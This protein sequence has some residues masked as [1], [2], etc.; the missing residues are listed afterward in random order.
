MSKHPS[1]RGFL[2]S[3][4]SATGATAVMTTFPPVIQRALAVSANNRTGTIRDVEH[5]VILMQENRSFDHYFGT[6]NGVR[7]FGD[8]FPIPVPSTTYINGRTV[9]V[10]PN[11]SYQAQPGRP[12]S[13]STGPAAI[14]PF[15]LNTTQTFA[16]MRVAGTPHSWTDAQAAWDHGR[17]HQWTVAKNNH[18]LGYFTQADMP[19][20]FALAN[21]F[22][23][24]DAYHAGSQTGTNTNRTFHWTGG[25]DPRGLGGGPVTDNSHDWFNTDPK[26]DYTWT[27]YPERL[28]AAGVSWQ[29]YQ[30]MDDNFTDNPLAGFKS[31]RDAWYGRAGYSTALRERGV[32][33]RDLDKL[34][35]D[36]LENKLPQ[37]SWI[38]ATAEGSEHPG[39]SSPA[40]GADYTSR[41]LE[42]LV[43]N[44]DVWSKTVL[45]V[46]FDENDGFFDH[47]PPPAAPSYVSSQA[48]PAASDLAGAST[49]DTSGEYNFVLNGS[50]ATYL[51]RPYGMG[52]RVPM[53]VVSPWSKGG[54]VN[55]QVFDH[56]SVLRFIEARF[57]VAETNI[58][59]W[60]RAVAGD[61]SSAFNFVDPND[62]SFFGQ[63][64]ATLALANQARA[65]SGTTMPPTPST[66]AL[67][68]QA[69]GV[70]PSRALPYELHASCRIQP[71][72]AATPV[73]LVFS[74]TGTQ[75]AVFH[76]YNR[77]DLAA[78]P[79]RYTV[80][81]GK[82]LSGQWAPTSAGQYD[83]WVLGPAGFHRHFTGNARRVAAA[84]QP[85]PEVSV[86]YDRLTG[87]LVVKL[88]NGGSGPCSFSL[89]ANAYFNAAAASYKVL[90]RSEQA[91][92]FPLASSGRWYDFSV[93]VAGQTDFSRRFAGRMENGQHGISDPAMGGTAIA[94]QLV[95]G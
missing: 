17:M 19:F 31:F 80:G 83:L 60:R 35:T 67:P 16:H 41:V 26:T 73:E 87:D 37:V 44:P 21:A 90:A 52:P 27:T 93:S 78:I 74:N 23:L 6:L 55:S 43:A 39:P 91:V 56:T 24:C 51:N 66:L 76:V 42:A 82:Q 3:V 64:P 75:A 77:K 72:L 40:Q 63:L 28:Q 1:R 59:P 71:T 53:Y 29:V 68:T 48:N 69:T 49:V 5:I 95:I 38:I 12:P 54:W 84:A 30:N 45:I 86:S 36:V 88:L 47:V 79:R 14:A 11:A 58:T 18:S 65:L 7:G 62:N 8:R 15:R 94:N 34:K 85:N 20:Q 46:N 92:R 81:P 9:W 22:T 70:R 89:V 2:R 4:A 57:G 61:L 25:N 50:S 32:S 13:A 33:T 10:Q